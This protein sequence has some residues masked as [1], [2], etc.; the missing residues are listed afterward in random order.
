[1]KDRKAGPASRSKGLRGP[2]RASPWCARGST[3]V[4]AAHDLAD[5]ELPDRRD[6]LR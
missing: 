5:R 1:M 2:A 6:F 4:G 3:Q